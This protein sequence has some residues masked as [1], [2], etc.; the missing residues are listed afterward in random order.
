MDKAQ[1]HAIVSDTYERPDIFFRWCPVA[2]DFTLGPDFLITNG[3]GC[4]DLNGIFMYIKSYN[5]DI[6]F[7]D[8][9][10]YF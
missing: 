6:M 7:H 10:P 8:L 3:F 5:C 2:T 9:P 1:F 4:Y